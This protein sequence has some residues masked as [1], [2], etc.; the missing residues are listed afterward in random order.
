ML[1]HPPRNRATCA[2]SNGIRPQKPTEPAKMPEQRRCQKEYT[3][4]RKDVVSLAFTALQ[5]CVPGWDSN[6]G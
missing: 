3:E 2:E 1:L 5:H 6:A 4:A